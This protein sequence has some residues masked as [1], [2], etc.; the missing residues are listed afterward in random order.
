[1]QPKEI[2]THLLS[3][4][5]PPHLERVLD[6]SHLIDFI[7]HNIQHK[8]ILILGQAAQG[9]STLAA[10]YVRKAGCP[11]AWINVGLQ[12]SDPANL[13]QTLTQAVY[14]AT[15]TPQLLEILKYPGVA[16]GIREERLLYREWLQ[17]LVDHIQG[18]LLLVLDGLDRLAA[19]APSH[20]LLDVSWRFCLPRY[21][22]LSRVEKRLHRGP[23]AENKSEAECA[24]K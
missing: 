9:K 1:M 3:R 2:P 15:K 18:P 11:C 23:K 13:F 8:I 17:S 6:R 19:K 24:G 16:M 10:S 21:N 12:E 4:I 5:S 14:G 22:S 20:T 7:D